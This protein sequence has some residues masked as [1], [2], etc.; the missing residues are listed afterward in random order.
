[1]APGFCTCCNHCHSPRHSPCHSSRYNL[2]NIPTIN[3][4]EAAQGPAEGLA[5]HLIE[6]ASTAGSKGIPVL[7]HASIPAPSH[8]STPTPAPAFAPVVIFIEELFK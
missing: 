3:P 1:M 4:T 6:S 2:C 7:S 8:A 5:E